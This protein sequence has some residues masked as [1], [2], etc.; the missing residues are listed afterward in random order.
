MGG[1]AV[2][3]L[4][5]AAAGDLAQRLLTGNKRGQKR[6]LR[7]LVRGLNL[8]GGSK[9]LDFGCGAGL[10]APL[11]ADLGLHYTGFDIE[12]ASLRYG[13][14]LHSPPA[15]FTSS[16]DE[17]AELGPHGCILANCCFHHIPDREL[18]DLLRRFRDML[19]PGGA[20]LLV[21]IL[22]VPDDPSPLRRWF[23]PLE[24]GR[25]VLVRS[26]YESIVSSHFSIVRSGV[27]RD[28]ILSI[29]WG[30]LPIGN[31]LLYLE[32]RP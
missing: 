21:D 18:H 3:P 17:A 15:R 11:F 13:G 23:M 22:A 2:T 20:F 25:H 14:L 26:G 12:A 19:M 8:P 5:R 10:F 16:L 32:C 1:L 9:V 31:N 4:L 29:P 7:G 28:N 27:D 24:Q 6:R 30:A